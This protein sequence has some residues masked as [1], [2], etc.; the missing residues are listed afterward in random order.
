M[1]NPWTALKS[2]LSKPNDPGG[3]GLRVISLPNR[4]AGIPINHDS[5]LTYSAI[6]RSVNLISESIAGLPWGVS[7]KSINARGRKESTPLMGH[8]L[9]NLL[10]LAANDEMD[11]LAFRQTL[12]AWALTWGNGYAEIDR[13][14]AGRPGALWSIEPNRV[15]V[16]RDL[17]GRLVYD[18]SNGSAPNTVLRPDQMFHLKG[19][20]FDGLVGY[21]VIGYAAKTVGLGLATE[22]YGASFYENGAQASMIFEHPNEI[23]TEGLK[24]LR[25]SLDSEHKGVA[26]SHK[27]MILEEGMTAKQIT[28]PQDDAQFIESRKFQNTEVCRWF[29][30]PP[31]KIFEM[32]Q[33]TFNNIEQQNI[34]F[35]TDALLIWIKRLELEANLKLVSKRNRGKVVT[36]INLNGLLRGDTEARGNFYTTMSTLGAFTVNDILELEDKN[37]IGPEGDKHL[38]QLNLTTLDKVGEDKPE[39]G[40][41][42]TDD[43]DEDTGFDLIENSMNKIQRREHHRAVEALKTYDTDR[44]GLLKHLNKFYDKHADYISRELSPIIK[45]LK[46]EIDLDQFISQHCE[47]SVNEILFSFDDGYADSPLA[48]RSDDMAKS[49]LG[50]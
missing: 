35:A 43:E 49:L 17:S 25:E 22:Q 21:S 41:P 31:H 5:A 11:A 3:S 45:H 14:G 46:L 2:K 7:Q 27:N 48:T 12:I 16:D 15:N 39:T 1:I 24:N 50:I 23:G 34:E 20:G 13:D 18:I 28:I 36:K 6:W 32:E 29:G 42:A 26:K 33:S 44:D 37:P 30:V 10:D 19:L 47:N 40:K 8:P 38:V 9:S 4:M